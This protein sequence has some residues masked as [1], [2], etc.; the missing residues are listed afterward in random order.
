VLIRG[1]IDGKPADIL[2]D[3]AAAVALVDPQ[4]AGA[5]GGAGRRDLNGQM[6]VDS[7]KT[8]RFDLGPVSVTTDLPRVFKSD[9]ANGVI[10]RELFENAVVD[11][12]FESSTV[13]FLRPAEFRP[14]AGALE[15]ATTR[16]GGM[17]TAQI[18]ING[19][20]PLCVIVDLGSTGAL[21]LNRRAIRETAL[22][23]DPDSYS[24]T[25]LAGRKSV[26][27]EG[28]KPARSVSIAGHVLKNVF[29]TPGGQFEDPCGSQLGVEVLSA[30]RLYM[31]VG[32]DRIWLAPRPG[33]AFDVVLDIQY[34]ETPT[35]RVVTAVRDTSPAAGQIK[36]GDVIVGLRVVDSHTASIA[37]STGDVRTIKTPY[38][39]AE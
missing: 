24:V 13:A 16:S 27:S 25:T 22:E 10:G 37:L 18:S 33:D 29:V 2:L 35:G 26:R 11:L 7:L 17:P 6:R 5:G 9:T 21:S 19:G 34:R 20:A 14:P 31:D 36:V 4:L 3:S 8:A 30:F 12:D 32:H 15:L 38:A 28:V 1:A 23:K 39:I